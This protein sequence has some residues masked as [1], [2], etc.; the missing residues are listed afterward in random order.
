MNEPI[1]Y[2]GFNNGRDTTEGV[3]GKPPYYTNPM[4][5]ELEKKAEDM[6]TTKIVHES[7]EW[8][9]KRLI[10]QGVP[11]NEEQINYLTFS[12]RQ[13]FVEYA[14]LFPSPD[15]FIDVEGLD[16]RK[17][18]KKERPETIGEK[19]KEFDNANYT[20]WLENKYAKHLESKR[21]SEEIG[22]K[23]LLDWLQKML[24]SKDNYCEIFFAGLRD[25]NNDATCFQIESSPEKF[26]T[27][28]AINI[29]WAIKNAML[30]TTPK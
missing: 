10:I 1:K 2:N 12:F 9:N 8:A 13:A 28:N 16:L 5:P 19:D 20:E 3:G 25:G 18:F 23:E 6:D 14:K 7:I 27:L 11:L 26:P 15:V 24:T 21:E 29:R 30:R 17:Q 4:N 22:D